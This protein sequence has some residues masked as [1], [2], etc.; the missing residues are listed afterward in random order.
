MFISTS[1]PRVVWQGPDTFAATLEQRKTLLLYK[2]LAEMSANT[3]DAWRGAGLK[4][5][6]EEPWYQ[7]AGELRDEDSLVST[8]SLFFPPGS[9]TVDIEPRQM[10]N[11]YPMIDH[12]AKDLPDSSYVSLHPY[13]RVGYPSTQ[14]FPT[15]APVQDHFYYTW[16]AAGTTS[17]FRATLTPTQWQHLVPNNIPD[18]Y[19]GEFHGLPSCDMG[20]RAT[21]N[22][23]PPMGS[24]DYAPSINSIQGSFSSSGASEV[25]GSLMIGHDHTQIPWPSVASSGN[26][27]AI[28]FYPQSGQ[29]PLN[30]QP[31]QSIDLRPSP[32]LPQ[33]DL[34]PRPMEQTVSPK[35]LRI[36]PSPTHKSSSE[37]NHTNYL[38][39]GSESDR[40]FTP[41]EA[42]PPS[43]PTR[44][45]P[46][47]KS[48]R[49]ARARKQ[50]PDKSSHPRY[51]PLIMGSSRRVASRATSAEEGSAPSTRSKGTKGS[52]RKQPKSSGKS[53]AAT[54]TAASK[55]HSTRSAAAAAAAARDSERAP[56][57]PPGPMPAPSSP[58]ALSHERSL[59]DE[60]LVRS[61]LEGMTYKEI[62]R[63]GG[64]IEAESTLRGR[65]RTL[66]KHRD[67]RVRK[68]EWTE[69]DVSL[70]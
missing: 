11:G 62:R 59:R 51:M 20:N 38:A 67:A 18:Q 23:V 36:N 44:Q 1:G 41:L 12:S 21:G 26:E 68:P 69:N 47:S 29:L 7:Q 58:A 55:K 17:G 46:S 13:S 10:E 43:D 35:L 6:P 33:H 57:P 50:L 70:P 66:T 32:Q 54:T 5:E 52:N 25:M 16:P 2:R 22:M 53:S 65:F 30:S 39:A 49:A 14:I 56:S 3:F 31:A 42:E 63:K 37:S 15:Q 34:F 61:K 19:G 64:F 40:V 60:F 8:R 27:P 48:V 28:S 4:A 24:L 45:Q 9:N